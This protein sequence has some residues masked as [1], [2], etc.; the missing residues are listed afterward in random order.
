[1]LGM[2]FRKWEP[3]NYQ[4]SFAASHKKRVLVETEYGQLYV[5]IEEGAYGY[6]NTTPR[7]SN[8]KWV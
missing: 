3:V 2:K 7:V 4:P 6:Y 5:E 8:I 1:M